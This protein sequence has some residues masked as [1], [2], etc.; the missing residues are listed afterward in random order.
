MNLDTDRPSRASTVVFV[1]Y[2][3]KRPLE[4]RVYFYICFFAKLDMLYV[5]P[6]TPYEFRLTLSLTPS[7][8]K[9]A[10]DRAL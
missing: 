5:I 1:P 9:R 3:G 10:A 2:N 7:L 8:T 6:I 4:L